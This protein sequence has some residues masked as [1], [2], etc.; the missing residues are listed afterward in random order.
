MDAIDAK[1]L[2]ILQ[3]DASQSYA[4]LGGKVG[5]S[6]SAVNDRVRKLRDQGI[7]RAYRIEIDPLAVGR[8]LMAM[9][10]LRSDP[11]KSSRKMIKSLIKA[12]EVME[13][14]HMTGRFDFLLK[15]RLRDT[16]HLESF[17]TDVIKELPGILEVLPEIAL[18]TAKETAFIPAQVPEAG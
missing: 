3:E 8:A 13:C 10:W 12:D 18:S 6:V 4:V 14:H 2:D 17:V 16:A 7:I 9:V 15:L 11:G 5:L 1:L